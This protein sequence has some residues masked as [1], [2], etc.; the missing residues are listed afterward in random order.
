MKNIFVTFGDGT[1]GWIDARKRIV[2]EAKKAEL[3]ETHIGLDDKWL[4]EWAPDAFKIMRD[5]SIQN[6]RRGHGYWIWKPALLLWADK[7]FPKHQI[8]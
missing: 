6:N 2:R 5:F 1:K 4:K 8:L 7:L 3:F